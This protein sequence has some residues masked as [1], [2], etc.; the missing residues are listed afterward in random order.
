MVHQLFV[1]HEAATTEVTGPRAPGH[2]G[3]AGR[4]VGDERG[5]RRGAS[6]GEEGRQQGPPDQGE[7]GSREEF[8][9]KIDWELL[10]AD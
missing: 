6:V 10:R 4:A 2:R 9:C 8:L 5:G 3:R 1:L 7:A